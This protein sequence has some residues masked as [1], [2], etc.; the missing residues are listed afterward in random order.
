[1]IPP[2]VRGATEATSDCETTSEPIKFPMIPPLVRGA[3]VGNTDAVYLPG[4]VERRFPM[5]PPLVRGATYV[6]SG[7][8]GGDGQHGFQ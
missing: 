8:G 3:T 1:M 6:V 4:R 2:L 5:I 7:T